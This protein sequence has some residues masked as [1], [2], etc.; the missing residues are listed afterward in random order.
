MTILKSKSIRLIALFAA[1]SLL[2]GCEFK[3]D[4]SR[5]WSWG[6]TETD[7]EYYQDKS[8]DLVDTITRD[9]EEYE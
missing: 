9:V 8:D 4:P 6:K 2:A 3:F 7:T 5:I 1:V